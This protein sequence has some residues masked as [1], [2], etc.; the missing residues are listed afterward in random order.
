VPNPCC[1][2]TRK[3]HQSLCDGRGG[4]SRGSVTR[5]RIGC[6]AASKS[7]ISTPRRSGPDPSAV[8]AGLHT[9]VITGR[10]SPALRRRCKELDITYVTK[11]GAQDRR[12]RGRA[13]EKPARRN[14]GRLLRDDLPDLMV[15]AGRAPVPSKRT[16]ESKTRRPTTSPRRLARQRRRR[17]LV[18]PDP[19][20]KGIG[21]R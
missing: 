19:K 5:S 9:G 4:A 6:S 1:Q 21:T 16:D 11:T 10:G 20:S 2:A 12:L 14:R 15:C 3:P 7:K 18:E 8:T 17:E 13:A